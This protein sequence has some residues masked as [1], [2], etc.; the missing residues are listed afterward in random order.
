MAARLPSDRAGIS[1]VSA[2][3]FSSTVASQ[4]VPDRYIPAR[5]SL[6]TSNFLNAPPLIHTQRNKGEAKVGPQRKTQWPGELVASDTSRMS[7]HA[8][9]VDIATVQLECVLRIMPASEN[10]RRRTEPFPA[11]NQL[12]GLGPS[13]MPTRCYHGKRTSNPSNRRG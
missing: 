5:I 3:V 6:A 1:A 9:F 7:Y 12:V 8:S 10:H 11:K 13:A 2:S 4:A